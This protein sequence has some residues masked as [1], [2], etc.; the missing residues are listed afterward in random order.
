M[1]AAQ[2]GY[3]PRKTPAIAME[4]RQRPQVSGEMRHGPGGGIA[5]GVQVGAPVVGNHTLGVAGGARCVTHGNGVPLVCR[6]LQLGQ[7]RMG[8][9]QR[10]VFMGTK[11]LARAGVFGIAHVDHL[12]RTAMFTGEQTQCFLHHPGKLGVGDQNAGF[13]VVQLPSQ[14]RRIEPGVQGVEHRIDGGHSVMR[15]NHLGGVGQHHAHRT[16]PPCPQSLQG[17]RQPRRALPR[18]RPGVATG[19][20]HYRRQITEHFGATL[21]KTH[22]RQR[23]VVGGVFIQVLVEDAG[24]VGYPIR[25]K[26]FMHVVNGPSG[27]APAHGYKHCTVQPAVFG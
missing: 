3:R 23:D 18:L 13:T 17:S 22:R 27:H 26:Y 25:S 9:Q 1:G 4:Q 10:F 7:R 21:H 12:Q 19:P 15:F 16:A 8:G 6:A 20:V 2:H 11:A 14:Q 24:H 5:H